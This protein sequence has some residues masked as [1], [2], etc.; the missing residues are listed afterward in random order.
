MTEEN[1]EEWD[2]PT[3][4]SGMDPEAAVGLSFLLGAGCLLLSAGGVATLL[5]GGFPSG[6]G[7]VGVIVLALGG[8]VLV[9]NAGRID[10]RLSERDSE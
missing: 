6:Y 10:G 7:F 8:L 9:F 2:D 5:E 4:E 3:A 1:A